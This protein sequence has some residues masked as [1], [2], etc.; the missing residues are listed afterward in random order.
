MNLEDK[1]RGKK[2]FTFEAQKH[3]N[4]SHFKLKGTK[5]IHISSSKAQ[6]LFTFGAQRHKNYH[7]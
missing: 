3:K 2:L 5:I 1:V 6:K 7:T 4:Y